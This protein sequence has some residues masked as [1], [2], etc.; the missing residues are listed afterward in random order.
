MNTAIDQPAMPGCLQR[1]VRP[2]DVAAL[3]CRSDTVYRTISGVDVWDQERDARKWP[4]GRPVIAH[5][6][7]RS[8]SALSHQ[9]KA[10]PEEK[11]LAPLAVKFVRENGGV[12]EHPASSKLWRTVGLPEPGETDEWGGWTMAVPQ[13]WWGH[14]ANKPTRLY[15][16]GCKPKDLPPIPLKLGEA[17]CVVTTSKRKCETPPSEWRDRLGKA[18]MEATPEPFAKW[19]VQVASLCRPNAPDQRPGA[20]KV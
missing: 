14:R 16:V 11:A 9:S 1:R 20:T 12:L 19:L 17:P 18:E 7:C 8:W 2:C 15:V 3:F 13:Y 4:G 10:P 6:P 5:P